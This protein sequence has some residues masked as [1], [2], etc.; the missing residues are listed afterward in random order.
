MP[1]YLVVGLGPI[2]CMEVVQM[3]YPQ[4][5]LDSWKQTYGL[6]AEDSTCL[7]CS[8]PQRFTVPFAYKEFRGLLSDHTRCGEEFRQ[9]KFVSVSE[10][11]NT[12]TSELFKLLKPSEVASDERD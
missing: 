5:N 7:K 2:L 9:S 4:V 11:T 1:D 6:T 8:E 10:E 3:I 12:S